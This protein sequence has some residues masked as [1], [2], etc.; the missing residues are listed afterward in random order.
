MAVHRHK[1][2]RPDNRI[3]V[4]EVL[5]HT[6]PP[7]KDSIE[8]LNTTQQTINI[9]GWLLSDT[10]SDLAKYTFPTN[11]TIVPGAYLVLDESQFNPNPTDPNSIGFALSSSKGDS[12]WLVEADAQG[13]PLR[14]V[15]H[16]EFPL[17]GMGK[18]LGATNATGKPH[19]SSQSTLGAENA[20]PRV[21][22]LVVSEINY[23][24]AS[25]SA[26]YQ[27]IEIANTSTEYTPLAN[28][29]LR[30]SVDYDFPGC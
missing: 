29:K 1:R 12:V 13:K 14:F 25:G 15:D 11:T 5:T 18:L 2:S 10:A 20:L 22:P 23:N 26:G 3:V 4:N 16:I 17:P 19:P 21:G 8:L 9:S 6:D 27:F 7:L 28:W 30:G 24:P